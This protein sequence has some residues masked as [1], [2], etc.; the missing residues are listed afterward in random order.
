[1]AGQGFLAAYL[2]VG[3]DA[4]KRQHVF[5]R[6][7]SRISALGDLDFNEDVFSGPSCDG[8]ALLT[9]C[10]TPP[11][12]CEYRLVVVKDAE[13]LPKAVAD[14][15]VD[16]LG[17]P[18]ATTVLYLEAAKLGK[19]T[20]LYKACAEVG[21][22]AVIDCTPRKA[23]DLPAKV[24]DFAASRG[25]AIT[26]AAAQELVSLVGE[27]TM[28][29]D[30][31]IAKIVAAVGKGATIGLSD[32]KEN[33]AATAEPKPWDLTDAL[34]A[35]DARRCLS[36]RARM[37]SQSPYSLLPRCV[38]TLRELLVAKDLSGRGTAALASELGKPAWMVKN[39]QRWASGFT[40]RELEGALVS[41]AE[42]EAGM[43]SGGDADLLFDCWML[44]V[45]TRSASSNSR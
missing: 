5:A 15:L 43:K 12:A 41:A 4:R 24:R 26:P 30:A 42:C 31:E 19:N 28:R 9:A 13:H 17:A 11:F 29:L 10:N 3:E 39:H 45:C 8:A 1:M 21:K 27:D 2:V 36:L 37:P 7:E 40:S 33:V 18:N 20:R 16:Y 23:R 32:V 25:A 38:T 14:A 34:A 6:M 22:Q 35:R 44:S